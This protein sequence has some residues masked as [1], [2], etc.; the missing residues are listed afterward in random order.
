MYYRAFLPN[1]RSTIKIIA[2][3]TNNMCMKYPPILN[4]KP[5]NQKKTTIPP[6]HLKNDIKPPPK[7]YFE[8]YII[9]DC[10][11]D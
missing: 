5:I 11:G 8:N 2:A 10:Y 1:I 6:N 4:N 3:T 7:V 9:W